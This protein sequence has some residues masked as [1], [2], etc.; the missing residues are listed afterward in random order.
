MLFKHLRWK[1]HRKRY[2]VGTATIVLGI[3]FLVWHCFYISYPADIASKLS[4]ELHVDKMKY[5]QAEPV[6]LTAS[7]VNNTDEP[8]EI[9]YPAK[10][11]P[12]SI[13][14]FFMSK[15]S[16]NWHEASKVQF[17][18]IVGGCG[19]G[20]PLLPPR[21]RLVIQPDESLAIE[22]WVLDSHT[23][24]LGHGQVEFVAKL[25]LNTPFA[26]K[27]K[28]VE[29]N[30]Q[31]I[32]YTKPQG[33]D[34]AAYDLISSRKTITTERGRYGPGF[35]RGGLIYSSGSHHGSPVH[36][37]FLKYHASTTYAPYIR[38]TQAMTHRHHRCQ[39]YGDIL[40]NLFATVPSDFPLLPEICIALLAYYGNDHDFPKMAELAK[41]NVIKQLT[42]FNPVTR[43]HLDDR[44]EQIAWWPPNTAAEKQKA[45]RALLKRSTAGGGP[46]LKRFTG[47]GG[48][49]CRSTPIL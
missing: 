21:H 25:V 27:A 36:E 26:S 39:E 11:R 45:Q 33:K 35:L 17:P 37:Y 34:K 47:G 42:V 3:G 9:S 4:L 32:E 15:D 24:D 13:S 6:R 41:S 8:I 2:F 5:V 44:L 22:A 29:S 38:Y 43:R 40:S 19:N 18:R 12:F 30:K 28:A 7:I 31:K 10:H 14:F 46:K 20:L 1:G 48:P 49:K 23:T 16:N